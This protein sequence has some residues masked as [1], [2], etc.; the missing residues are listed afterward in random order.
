MY[1][2]NKQG[3][4]MHMQYTQERLLGLEEIKEKIETLLAWDAFEVVQ[5]LEEEKDPKEGSGLYYI[6]Y[7]M[8]DAAECFLSL[9]GASLQGE[10]PDGEHI[11]EVRLLEGNEKHGL[12]LRDEE[13]EATTLWF[14]ACHFCLRLYAY[15]RIL[16]WW[17][18]GEEQLRRLVYILGTIYDKGRY[19]G[20]EYLSEEE[21]E[22]LP[23]IESPLLRS[24]RPASPEYCPDY[25]DTKRGEEALL[26]AAKQAGDK[27]LYKAL[28]ILSHPLLRP[29]VLKAAQER[30]SKSWRFY[31][32]I[33][34]KIAMASSMYPKRRYAPA[35]EELIR[36]KRKEMEAQ[37]QQEGYEGTYPQFHKG[38][39]LATAYEEHPFATA[40][41]EKLSFSIVLLQ[42]ERKGEEAFY[43][44]RE[45]VPGS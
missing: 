38:D 31:H 21:K 42:E 27:K 30:L 18:K 35:F 6:P 28:K 43:S 17:V 26:H 9:Q 44:V 22:L 19:L 25:P 8:N 32:Y 5:G 36:Q 16:H 13:G 40:G 7:M 14:S 12:Y 15:H 20:E 33:N 10:L 24:F 23:F 39:L 11:Q 41:M 29:F 34:D 2:E 37:M 3:E 45:I 1:M 4:A